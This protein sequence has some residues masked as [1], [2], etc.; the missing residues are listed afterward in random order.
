MPRDIYII[1]L[2]STFLTKKI[3]TYIFYVPI[4][5]YLCIEKPK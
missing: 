2:F 5:I 1:I 3:L 4:F